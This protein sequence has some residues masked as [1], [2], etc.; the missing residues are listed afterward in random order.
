MSITARQKLIQNI[1]LKLGGGIVDLELDPEHYDYAVDAAL[2]RYRQRSGNAIEESF[3]FIDLQPG[4][5]AYTLPQEVQE[6]RA[7]YRR[8]TGASAGGGAAVDPF[9]LAFTNNLYLLQ[10]SG[11]LGGGGGS[12]KLSTYDFAMQYQELV[13]RMFGRD[14]LFTWDAATRRLTIQRNISAVE[15]IMLHAYNIRP[16]EI[17]LIDPYA[18]PWIRDYAAATCKMMLG[19]ARSKFQSLGGPQGGV[20]LN[21]DALK[22]EAKEEMERLEEEVKTQIDAHEGYGFVIG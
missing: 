8:G 6:I 15:Q 3:V 16:E 7:L 9:S 5:Q 13:G 17:L 18:K 1:Q 21:G 12:G 10:N 22:S 2:D 19:E 20:S 14:M 11:G 4:V